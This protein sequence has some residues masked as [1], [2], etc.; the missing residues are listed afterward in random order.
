MTIYNKRTTKD[1]VI[2]HD[3]E[4]GIQVSFHKHETIPDNLVKGLSQKTKDKMKA[5]KPWNKGKKIPGHPHSQET[6]KKLSEMRKGKGNPNFGKP[7]S[8]EQR[9]K[10]SIAIKKLIEEGKWTPHVHNSLTHTRILVN[11]KKFRSSWEAVF[12]SLNSGLDYEKHR[13][14][15]F[16]DLKDCKRVY[17]TDFTDETNKIIYEI[18]PSAHR[19]RCKDKFKAAY[20]WCD[21]NGYEFIIVDEFWFKQ[22]KSLI[23]KLNIPEEIKKKVM[24]VK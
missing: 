12:Y 13:I 1:K 10:Q 21:N 16:D 9:L 4:T 18:K 20:E 14:C 3:P 8:E 15:Y 19:E 24:N 11:G 17:I 22:R 5:R 2:F 7:I 23:E 6:K